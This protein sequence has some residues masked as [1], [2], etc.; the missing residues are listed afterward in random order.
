MGD[1]H[2]LLEFKGRAAK[3]PLTPLTAW[4]CPLYLASYILGGLTESILSFTGHR[5][6]VPALPYRTH[7]PTCFTS[8][9]KGHLLLPL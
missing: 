6:T 7:L 3:T 9:P 1:F 5:N 8:V 4:K 2:K